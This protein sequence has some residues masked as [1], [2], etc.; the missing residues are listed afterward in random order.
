MSTF[1]PEVGKRYVDNQKVS[2]LSYI[3]V[4]KNSIAGNAYFL[5][6]RSQ[7]ENGAFEPLNYKE[8]NNNREDDVEGSP[9]D[10]LTKTILQRLGRSANRGEPPSEYTFGRTFWVSSACP[11][12]ALQGNQ[13][14]KPKDL[15]TSRM[16]LWFPQYLTGNG[17]KL[18]CSVLECNEHLI[19]KCF[20]PKACRVIDIKDSFYMLTSRFVCSKSAQH[21]FTGYDNNII[22][23]LPLR[24]QNDFPA[25]LTLKSG[26]SSSLVNLI[27]PLMQNSAG[28]GRIHKILREIHRLRYDNLQFQYLD[29]ALEYKDSSSGIVTYKAA[30][31]LEFED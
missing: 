10:E 1:S 11:S 22:R 6:S 2:K 3:P 13:P 4:K 30:D 26:L 14:P 18:L 21:N 25:L 23:Q 5:S 7:E 24:V 8:N 12:F 16:F 9:V 31:F 29:A 27:R 17:K 20:T 15:Y 28:P 19:V